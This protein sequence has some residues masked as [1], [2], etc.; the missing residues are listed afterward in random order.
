MSVANKPSKFIS[1]IETVSKPGAKIVVR[2][3]HLTKQGR[4]SLTTESKGI[5]SGASKQ[6]GTKK[7]LEPA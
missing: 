3:I 6:W 5:F 7:K 2:R 1:K 4:E